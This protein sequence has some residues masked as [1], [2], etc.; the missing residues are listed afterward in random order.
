M[1]EDDPT[2]R[3]VVVTKKKIDQQLIVQSKAAIP[4]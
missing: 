3:K 1:V 4:A 2:F